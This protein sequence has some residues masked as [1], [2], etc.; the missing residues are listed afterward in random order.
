MCNCTKLEW[1][2][3]LR[4]VI[5]ATRIFEKKNIFRLRP[6]VSKTL[7]KVEY[8]HMLREKSFSISKYIQPEVCMLS[9]SGY[10]YY[11]AYGCACS[12]CSIV[13]NSEFISFFLLSPMCSAY[14]I[15]MVHTLS[16]SS[17]RNFYSSMLRPKYANE[18]NECCCL[19]LC[20]MQVLLSFFSLLLAILLGFK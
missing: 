17:L 7:R 3:L 10:M 11:M 13:S 16:D 5:M 4:F 12:G 19:L 15:L 2:I 6:S 8:F 1:K 14:K 9:C 20:A 18:T